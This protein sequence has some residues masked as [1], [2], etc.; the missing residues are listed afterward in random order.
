MTLSDQWIVGFV[1]GEGCFSFSLIKN[2]SL[3]FG[4]Q[5]QGEFT[6]VQHKRDIQL[7]HKLKSY[8]GCGSVGPNHG[9]RYHFRVKNLDHFLTVIIPYFEKHKL[10]TVKQFQLPVFKDICL[11]LQAKEHFNEEGFNQIKKLVSKL[12]DLKKGKGNS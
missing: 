2:D 12:S 8:F 9:D 3:R 7:L 6:V 4:Y 10:Q 11:R 5:I 1:D